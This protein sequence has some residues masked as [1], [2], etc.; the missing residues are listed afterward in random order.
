MAA[1]CSF[2][3]KTASITVERFAER[4]TA[5][6]L[7]Y[8]DGRP[9]GSD[10]ELQQ[11][12]RQADDTLFRNVFAV[13]LS[14]LQDFKTLSTSGVSDRIFSAGVAGA[15]R[16]AR[17]AIKQLTESADT[18]FKPRAQS[19][20]INKALID[21]EHLKQQLTVARLEAGRYTE[22]LLEEETQSARMERLSVSADEARLR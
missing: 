11:H 8:A 12:L 19:A 18:L 17:E 21:L 20:L 2:R 5:V 7:I 14:E 3:L 16:S 9:D 15:G 1:G 10:A 22:L 6:R 4:N 13:S